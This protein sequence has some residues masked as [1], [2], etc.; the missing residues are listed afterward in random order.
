MNFS[1]PSFLKRAVTIPRLL[2]VVL[3]LSA[4]TLLATASFTPANQPNGWLAQV[5]VSDFDL[6]SNA[7]TVYET[8]YE[9]TNYS[10]N[11]LAYPVGADGVIDK[12][13]ERWTG[14]AA[15]NITAQNY[16]TGRIIFTMKSDGTRIPFRWASLAAAQQSTLGSSSTGP[17]ILDF[18]RGDRSNETP[19]G[20]KFRA[21][22]ISVLG[23]IIHSRPNYVEGTT[24]S[25]VYVG[26][27]DGMLHAIDARTGNERYAY[28]PSMLIPSL[29]SLA[30][31]APTAYTHTWFVDATPG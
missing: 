4:G 6:S 5:E 15:D 7:E 30:P 24:L 1:L 26:A 22:P 17:K 18:V 25:T 27:N 9:L 12:A 11:L 8:D 20:A 10:G 13:A 19:N 21:R 2:A 3:A 14:G 31:V 29:P 16:D 28:V 23:D